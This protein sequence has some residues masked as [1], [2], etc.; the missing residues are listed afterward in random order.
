[1]R[2]PVIASLVGLALACA[3]PTEPGASGLRA[4]ATNGTV[5]LQNPSTHRLFYFIL[6]RQAAAAANWA[7]CVEPAC[8]SLAPGDGTS[9]PYAAIGGYAPGQREAIV[10]WW[11]AQARAGGSVPGPIHLLVLPL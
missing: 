4:Q 2:S 6:E 10:W 3:S 8:P 5:Q 7:A 1:M 9:L 11:E